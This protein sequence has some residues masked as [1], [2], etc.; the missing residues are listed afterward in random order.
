M[1]H[2][3]EHHGDELRTIEVVVG[4]ARFVDD[5]QRVRPHVAFG[6][7]LR[8]LLAADQRTHLGQHPIDDAEVERQREAD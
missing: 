2:G 1:T 3:A 4:R 7:P 8:L 6:M 5:H